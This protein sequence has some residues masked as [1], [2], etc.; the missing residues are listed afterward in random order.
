MYV[1]L[2]GRISELTQELAVL[3]GELEEKQA[4]VESKCRTVTV[5]YCKYFVCWTV[6]G[7]IVESV[8]SISRDE[9]DS[10]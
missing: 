6:S 5:T 8:D 3:E 9:P 1:Y 4:A 7:P 10:P 2:Q